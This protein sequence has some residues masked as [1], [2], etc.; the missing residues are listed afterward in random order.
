M[1]TSSKVVFRARTVDPNKRLSIRIRKK[2]RNW[3]PKVKRAITIPPSG[4]EKEEE[5]VI[6][7]SSEWPPPS[8]SLVSILYPPILCATPRPLLERTS[9][10]FMLD[11][12]ITTFFNTYK[13]CCIYFYKVSDLFVDLLISPILRMQ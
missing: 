8:F 5:M 10:Y 6:L 11:R 13:T 4:M 12:L 7:T 3:S 1:S 9:I 2:C